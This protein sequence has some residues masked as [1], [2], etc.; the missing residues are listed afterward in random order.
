MKYY[1]TILGVFALLFLS[2][3]AFAVEHVRLTNENW[4]TLPHPQ[5]ASFAVHED[6]SA[7]GLTVNG[8]PFAQYNVPNE[9]GIRVQRFEIEDH[10]HYIVE[11]GI[12]DTEEALVAYLEERSR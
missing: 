7:S 8:I 12:I 10:Y 2:S 6:G 9:F 1:H 11:D 5:V 3:E 4:H